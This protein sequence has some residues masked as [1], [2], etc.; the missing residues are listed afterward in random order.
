M[1]SVLRTTW[2]LL[3]GV[4]LL[5]VGNGMQGTLLGIR[6]GIESISTDRMS[7]VMASYFAGFLLGSRTAPALIQR[8]GHVRVFAA[9]GSLISAVLI[10]YAAVPN[11]VAWS[12]LRLLIGFSFSGVYITAESWLNASTSNENRGQAMSTYMIVQMTGLVSA[13][14][15]VNLGDPGGFLLFILPSVLVSLAFTPI[16]LSVQPAPA[17]GALGR[18][19]IRQLYH[20]SPLGCIGIF[21][22]GGVFSALLGMTPV[23]GTVVGLSVRDISAIIAAVY[24]GGLILQFPIGWISDRMDRRHLVLYLLIVGIVAVMLQLTANPGI[25]G[26]LLVAGIAGAV[27]NPVYALLLAHTND[28]LDTS[29]MAAASAG[30]I[31]LNGL[32]A[33]GG[34]LIVGRLMGL[35]GPNGFWIF[36]VTLMIAL[37]LYTAW[38]MNRR[39]GVAPADTGNFAVI[40]PAATTI[41]VGAAIEAAQDDS[42]ASEDLGDNIAA[43]DYAVLPPEDEAA[44]EGATEPAPEGDPRT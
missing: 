1:I 24:L 18:M 42:P 21:L 20:V 12:F 14:F 39:E 44:P 30:L 27:S 6:G 16:L 2:P 37:A 4:M 13:Q 17:F 5:L 28:H 41:A 34:P 23:W 3:L 7:V 33:V 29:D 19:S 38:R 9:L 22:M 32:G 36:I 10:L 25:W 40:V 35:L 15:L 11:W 8:V 26:T 31:F 43:A